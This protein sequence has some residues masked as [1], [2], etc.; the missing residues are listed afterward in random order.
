MCLAFHFQHVQERQEQLEA[1][2]S[3][4]KSKS[5]ASASLRLSTSPTLPS[6]SPSS[7]FANT[8]KPSSPKD[9]QLARET[10]WAGMPSATSGSGTP[11]GFPALAGATIQPSDA[12]HQQDDGKPALQTTAMAVTSTEVEQLCHENATTTE[13]TPEEK[14][15]E[16]CSHSSSAACESS[17]LSNRVLSGEGAVD[18]GFVYLYQG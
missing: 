1:Q 2:S 13:T 5:L 14:E 15:E 9:V 10:I 3:S 4:R 11:P 6:A 7:P 8:P 18:E 12:G 16:E 17:L